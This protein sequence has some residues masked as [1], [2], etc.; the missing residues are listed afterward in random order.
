MSGIQVLL[1][2]GVVAIFLYYLFRL[3]SALID[4]VALGLFSGLAIFF[5]LSPEYTSAIAQKLGVGRGA[6]M[7]FYICILFFLFVI[8]KLYA[9]V[10]RLEET[11]TDMVRQQA[12]SEALPPNT[13]PAP[14][15]EVRAQSH[16]L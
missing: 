2:S 8:L 10:R 13:P 4:L 14:K 6:D 3:R 9:R 11:L 15:G 1:I 16:P 12:K 5:I 7:L